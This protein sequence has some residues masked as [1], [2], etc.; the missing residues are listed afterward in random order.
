MVLWQPKGNG[1]LALVWALAACLKEKP[2]EE[3]LLMNPCC[4]EGHLYGKE[5]R[6][7]WKES[8]KPHFQAAY[9]SSGCSG[10]PQ[11]AL[12]GRERQLERDT[13]RSMWRAESLGFAVRP[14]HICPQ[15]HCLLAV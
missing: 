3:V 10:L 6:K 9:R 14:G 1:G 2:V 8:T 11:G 15:P 5:A 7:S 13:L 4:P 12:L